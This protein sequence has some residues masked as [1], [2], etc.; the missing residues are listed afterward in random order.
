MRHKPSLFHDFCRPK[1]VQLTSCLFV[2]ANTPTM[3][4]FQPISAIIGAL[5]LLAT[6]AATERV[7]NMTL[8]RRAEQRI[9]KNGWEGSTTLQRVLQDRVSGVDSDGLSCVAGIP[10]ST[11]LEFE[12]TTIEYYYALESSEKISHTEV[13]QL[14]DILF[15]MVSSRIL[16]CT[17]L[18][19]TSPPV[20]VTIPSTRKLARMQQYPERMS[21]DVEFSRMLR[22]YFSHPFVFSIL[23]FLVSQRITVRLKRPED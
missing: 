23:Q 15:G 16:W 4:I 12:Y 6:D 7:E 21:I 14:E 1:K 17:S 3:R 10:S 18:T 11:D 5:F 2:D 9:T 20:N 8:R 13:Q 19:E 22:L